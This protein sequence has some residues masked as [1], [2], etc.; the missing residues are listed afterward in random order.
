MLPNKSSTLIAD[1]E[2]SIANAYDDMLSQSDQAHTKEHL[3]FVL[4]SLREPNA[5]ISE[6]KGA[7]KVMQIRQVK[8]WYEKPVGLLLIAIVSGLVVAGFAKY[9]GWV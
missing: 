9:F 4:K 8:P 5:L 6:I 3:S 7:L 2:K 1:I